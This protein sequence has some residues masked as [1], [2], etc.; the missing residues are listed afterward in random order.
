MKERRQ[1]SVGQKKPF[2][3]ELIYIWND[4]RAKIPGRSVQWSSTEKLHETS[5]SEE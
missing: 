5:I 2:A 3:V 4:I 1:D